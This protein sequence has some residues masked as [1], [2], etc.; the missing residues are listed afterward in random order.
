MV[1]SSYKKGFGHSFALLYPSQIHVFN[2]LMMSL[3]VQLVSDFVFTPYILRQQPGIEITLSSVTCVI[4]MMSKMS[5]M[6]FS[7]APIPT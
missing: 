2:C 4:L 1:C 7:T 3:A 6:F 5:S